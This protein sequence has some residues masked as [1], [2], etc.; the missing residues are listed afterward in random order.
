LIEACHGVDPFA[1][2]LDQEARD[3]V[4]DHLWHRR[5]KPRDDGSAASERIE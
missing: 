4:L 3:F 2:A 5:C 1:N